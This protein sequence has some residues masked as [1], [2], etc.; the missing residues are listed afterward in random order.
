MTTLAEMKGRVIWTFAALVAFAS[1]LMMPYFEG[2]SNSWWA[3]PP[4]LPAD[5]LPLL[6][7]FVTCVV[8]FSSCVRSVVS[9]RHA[10]ATALMFF[11][12]LL[13]FVASLALRPADLFQRGFCHY[14]RTVL[15]VDEWR[16]V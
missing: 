15:T 12:S 9:K 3:I 16:R 7:L 4:M 10:V 2:R 1:R 8:L 6:L 11:I 14:V 13:L 5:L